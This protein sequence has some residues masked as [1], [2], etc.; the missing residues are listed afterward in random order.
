MVTSLECIDKLWKRK[1]MALEK[2]QKLCEFVC[3]AFVAT[4]FSNS[5]VFII[6]QLMTTEWK[7]V[8]TVLL[9]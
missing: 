9:G 4:V 3:H 5:L 2:P 8:L 7:S 6:S 1:F